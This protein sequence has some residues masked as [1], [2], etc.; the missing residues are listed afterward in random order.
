MNPKSILSTAISTSQATA[1]TIPHL[2]F[3]FA[4]GKYATTIKGVI[5]RHIVRITQQYLLH[6]GGNAWIFAAPIPIV[7]SHIPR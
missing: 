4:H 2:P 1:Q 6:H 3:I 5:I 7:L